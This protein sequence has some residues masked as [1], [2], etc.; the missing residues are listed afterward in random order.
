MKSHNLI[1]EKL[2]VQCSVL[3]ILHIPP[4]CIRKTLAH[5]L[6]SIAPCATEANLSLCSSV[7]IK[8]RLIPRIKRSVLNFISEMVTPLEFIVRQE[9]ENAIPDKVLLVSK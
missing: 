8:L 3:R 1:S 4:V 6:T 5:Y 2:K 9:E 7:G